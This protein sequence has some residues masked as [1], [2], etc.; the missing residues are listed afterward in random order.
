M[1]TDQTIVHGTENFA[2]G[3]APTPNKA[4][5]APKL[6]D[7]VL[8][9]E[10]TGEIGPSNPINVAEMRRQMAR[11]Q[12]YRH[13]HLL[14][15]STG[16]SVNEAFAIFLALRSQP[17]PVSARAAGVCQSAAM[18]V[19]MAA[20][21]RSATDG[22]EFLN[23]P[24]NSNR[25]ILP[26]KITAQILIDRAESLKRTDI[27]VAQLLADRTGGHLEWFLTEG[28][29]EEPLSLSD[30]I[31]AGIVHEIEGVTESP[32]PAWIDCSTQ[33]AKVRDLYIP[34]RLLT[35]NYLSACRCAASLYGGREAAS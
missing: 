16:G 13:I 8:V 2:P 4:I 5:A 25:D 9:I 7:D 28:A 19:Y 34:R 31:E 12:A 22:T 24:T 11:K 3:N 10:M 26:E 1:A 21:F 29:T 20:D 17:V 6:A 15:S 18:I 27:K 35:Q 32:N 33:L 23:H 14:L 30:S